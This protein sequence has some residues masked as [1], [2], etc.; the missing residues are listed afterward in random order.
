M[1]FPLGKLPYDF[2]AKLLSQAPVTDPRV[3]IGPGSGLDCAV[4][5]LGER[6]LVF[7][8]DPITFTTDQIGWYAVQVNANDIATTGGVP[9]WMLATLLL[10]EGRA[11]PELVERIFDQ[12]SQAC[13]AL[14]ISL[15]GGHTEVTYG[16]DRP[17]ISAALVGEVEKGRLVRPDGA[18]PGNRLL[19]TKGV[20]VEAVS[21]LA[22][23]FGAHLKAVLSEDEL[24]EARD[25]LM[26][27]GISVV[28]DARIAVGAGRVRA[29]HDPTEGGLASALWE[30]AEASRVRLVVDPQAVRV[31]D[32]ARR[33]CSQLGIDP[34]ASIASGALLMAVEADD[35]DII[36]SALEKEGIPC[37]G[38]GRVESEGTPE[39]LTPD[40]KALV[41]PMRDEIAR[42]FEREG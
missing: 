20:P 22:R 11:T 25:Y 27:P 32:L 5:D 8:S 23:E 37:A 24:Q 33:I 21:I 1:L 9:R 36:A 2:L 34:L 12:L 14:G 38:I 30:L 16:L 13:A 10:P 28:R 41:R 19:L 18:R 7:K 6:Y 39:V 31:P 40:G 17:V 29:M 15:V 35:A 4:I 3:L 26:N 42:L